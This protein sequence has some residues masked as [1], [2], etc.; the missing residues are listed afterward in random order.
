MS[1]T[2]WLWLL[3]VSVG[4]VTTVA[5]QEKP[6]KDF[7]DL[8]ISNGTIIDMSLGL[9]RGRGGGGLI[10]PEGSLLGNIRAMDYDGVAADAAQLRANFVKVEAFWRQRKIADAI[11]YSQAALRAAAELEAAA[12]ARDD[13]A[14]SA[15][16]NAVTTTCHGCHQAHRLINL[17]DGTFEIR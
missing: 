12:R 11:K 4:L 13:E 17:V 9:A 6:P 14:I 16:T 5:A 10:A 3:A 7:Q 8:M 2:S 1:R 15:S